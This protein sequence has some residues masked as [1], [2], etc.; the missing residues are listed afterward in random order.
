MIFLTIGNNCIP[1]L[2]SSAQA[3]FLFSKNADKYR[4]GS[5]QAMAAM[6]ASE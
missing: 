2:A 3:S 5:P 1:H 4:D 6:P